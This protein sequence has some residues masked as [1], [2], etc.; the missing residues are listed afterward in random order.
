MLFVAGFVLSVFPLHAQFT[1]T[2]GTLN[3]TQTYDGAGV[4]SALNPDTIGSSSVDCYIGDGGG[5]GVLNVISGSLTINA[6][7]FK[8]GHGAGSNGTVDVSGGTLNINQINQWGGGIGQVTT[9]TLDIETG[10]TVNWQ[11]AGSV[12]Q[13]FVVGN[14]VG[15]NGIINLNGGTLSNTVGSTLTDDQ[16]Q[17]RV[18]SDS[19]AGTINLNSGTWNLTGALPFALG[20]KYMGLNSTATFDQGTT[21]SVMNITNGGFVQSG[22]A[23]GT[24]GL[25]TTESTFTVGTNDYVNFISGGTGYLSIE[26]WTQGDFETLVTGG[27]IRIDG[28]IATA[29]EFTYSST[30]GQGTYSLA[31]VPEPN[32]LVLCAV[33]LSGFLILIRRK[34]GLV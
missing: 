8:I 26:G 21:V 3:S 32:V 22:I 14:G 12:E 9:G 17:W 34:R 24:N 33:G 7:D 19:G 16:R 10:A 15:G 6:N 28:T 1:Y 11:V 31:A 18:G 4:D 5:T 13:R 2:G 29:N 20:G 30:G 23:G 27:Q 25:S